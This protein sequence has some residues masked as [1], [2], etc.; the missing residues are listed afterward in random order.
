MLLEGLT[1]GFITTGYSYSIWQ[2]HR[3]SLAVRE[4]LPSD[5][6]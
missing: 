2:Y 5:L 1:L 4:L 3:V 6:P